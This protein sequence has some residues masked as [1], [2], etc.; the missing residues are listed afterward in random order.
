MKK[1]MVTE[2]NKDT[3]QIIDSFKKPQESSKEIEG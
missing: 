2:G 1:K 3:T